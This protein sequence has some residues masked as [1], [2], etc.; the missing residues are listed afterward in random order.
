M[1]RQ[2]RRIPFQIVPGATRLL[3]QLMV[4]RA[5][6][7]ALFLLLVVANLGTGRGGRARVKPTSKRGGIES[8]NGSRS[9]RPWRGQDLDLLL[10][11]GQS[12]S[13]SPGGGCV[14]RETGTR[15][16]SVSCACESSDERRWNDTQS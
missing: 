11:S 3:L 16:S 1:S 12:G 13:T 2:Q 7:V 5:S 8:R 10:R 6:R 15:C 9:V 14:V 4:D